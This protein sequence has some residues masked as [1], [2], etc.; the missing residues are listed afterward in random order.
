MTGHV[1]EILHGTAASFLLKSSGIAFQ[2]L[3]TMVLTRMLGPK[4]AGFFFIGITILNILSVVSR[5]GSDAY[6]IKNVSHY[7]TLNR[8]DVCFQ[9]ISRILALSLILSAIFALAISS[10]AGPIARTVFHKER[11][12]TV[13][14]SMSPLLVVLTAG[15]VM[16]YGLQGFKRIVP[17]VAVQNL[18]TPFLATV[19]SIILISH[20]RTVGAV[21]AYGTGLTGGMLFAWA[22]LRRERNRSISSAGSRFDWRKFFKETRP[23]FLLSVVNQL[24]AWLPILLVGIYLPPQDVS[25]LQVTLRIAMLVSFVLLAA[26]SIVAPKVA[27][28]SA[29]GDIAT[30][31]SVLERVTFSITAIAAPIVVILIAFPGLILN[32]FGHEFIAAATILRVLVVAQFINI[33]SGPVF[34][35]L[36]MA[37]NVKT[38]YRI[39]L[40][41]LIVGLVI[42]FS[43]IHSFRLGAAVAAVSATIVLQNALAAIA[44]NMKYGFFIIP[45]PPR[46]AL[47][48]R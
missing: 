7:N 30:M 31:R 42:F 21:M 33:A 18:F 37:G 14:E 2:F 13:L 15:L 22:Q 16:S 9:Q 4:E 38:A 27:E 1:R 41:S 3:L 23:F 45:K 47:R 8:R 26:N 10:L 5:F 11:L 17:A 12:T 20:F 32:L 24:I 28:L 40:L 25:M 46:L 36:I 48:S 29:T 44:V 34:N 43:L 6:L 19:F 35:V 39:Q